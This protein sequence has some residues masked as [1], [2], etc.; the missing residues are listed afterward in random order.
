M[1]ILSG[2]T[3]LIRD[4]A[5]S[6]DGRLL[7]SGANDKTVRLWNLETGEARVLVEHTDLVT[8]VAFSPSGDSLASG[9]A[10]KTVRLWEPET[11]ACT[12]TLS[13][14][15]TFTYFGDILGGLTDLR[16]SRDGRRLAS[17]TSL[18]IVYLWDLDA[19]SERRFKGIK[20]H[21]SSSVD[22]APDG[23]WI[24]AATHEKTARIWSTSTGKSRLLKGFSGKG[25][26][27]GG[28]A[29]A[30]DGRFL[31]TAARYDAA[32]YVW[33]L[34]TLTGTALMSSS[35]GALTLR[36][37][38][39]AISPDAAWLARP[40]DDCTLDIWDV[41]A[42]SLR[43]GGAEAPAALLKPHE[44][45]VQSLCFSP[46]SRLLFTI[47]LSGEV[48]ASEVPSGRP[49]ARASVPGVPSFGA[50]SPDGRRLAITM[51]DTI[52]IVELAV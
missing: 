30:P 15:E 26:K 29:F 12:A 25:S 46:D 41:S 21:W 2:H 33:E 23:E 3:N 40:N 11:G 44:V 35:P 16:F 24:S 13:H 34:P 8:S 48:V 42:A 47:A 28:V 18:S 10:D 14:P 19:M 22:I 17:V 31:A 51:K 32:T 37:C 38:Q 49:V 36:G 27:V 6:P 52:A 9:S 1:R 4:L 7:A 39:F 20:K 45:P 43:G 50:F 5:F